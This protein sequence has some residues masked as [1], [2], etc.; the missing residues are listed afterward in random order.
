MANGILLKYNKIILPESLNN[1]TIRLAHSGGHPGCNKLK[2]RIQS[3]F[4]IKGL[5]SK[6][7]E[8]VS[9]CS[10]CQRSI[11]KTM[12]QP[13]Q[14]NKVPQNC[15]EEVSV[16][17]FGPLP[18][19]KQIV[20][21]QDLAS[22]YPI[23]KIVN[24][25]KACAVIPVLRETYN[26]FGNPDVQKSDNGPPFNSQQMVDFT[27]PRSITQIKTPPYHPAPNNAETDETAGKSHE[28]RACKQNR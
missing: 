6:V 27:A 10:D 18:S 19:R 25:T 7:T 5:D 13:I 26:T 22:R 17:L 23:A 1:Q 9:E 12:K 11:Q 20:V 4:Y 15:W 14:P 16:D 2:R 3:H 8:F 21:I 24:S 28:D